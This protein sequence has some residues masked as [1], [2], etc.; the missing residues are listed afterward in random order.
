MAKKP[1]FLDSLFDVNGD[2][3]VDDIDFMDDYAIY[4]MMRE[5]EDAERENLSTGSLDRM[6]KKSGGC[7]LSLLVM[8]APA[9]AV[10][11][12]LLR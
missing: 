2:G 11:G 7:M 10:L 6:S 12:L 1:G 5:D 8:I 3:K 9:I 4:R